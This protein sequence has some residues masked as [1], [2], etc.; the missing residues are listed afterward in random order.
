MIDLAKPVTLEKKAKAD[1]IVDCA[2]PPCKLTRKSGCSC[3]SRTF[4]VI[5]VVSAG[6]EAEHGKRTFVKRKMSWLPT[7][8]LD[9]SVMD[10]ITLLRGV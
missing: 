2:V 7:Q 3:S 10:R 8:D 9:R 5:L 4:S 1:K 6:K